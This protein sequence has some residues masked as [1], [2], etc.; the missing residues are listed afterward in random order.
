MLYNI[1]KRKDKLIKDKEKPKIIVDIH[2]KNSLVPSYLKEKEAEI[3]FKSLKIG[4]Y[5]VGNIII[6]RKTIQDFISSM[7]SKRLIL[8]LREL[9]RVKNKLFLL[10]GHID[11]E[12][13]NPNAIRGMLLSICLEIN[14]PLIFTKDSK[15]TADYLFLI[16]KKQKKSSE[17]SLHSRKGLTKK[18]KIQYILES[19]PNIGPST[20]KKL[21][22]KYKT[23]SS[24]FNLPPEEIKKEIGKKAEAFS[25]LKEEY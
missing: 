2:E 20:S 6:E 15:E 21:L 4:D 18:E 12:G 24:I 25:I 17:V 23:L 3:E 7:I 13:F 9:S 10:E 5:L 19:F 8:Q 22:K 1:F 14:I 16:S 11:E